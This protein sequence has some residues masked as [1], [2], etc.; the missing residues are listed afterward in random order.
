M[1]NER[2]NNKKG[3]TFYLHI[4]GFMGFLTLGSFVTMLEAVQST[5]P[6]DAIIPVLELGNAACI[7]AITP[8]IA[9]IIFGILY[10][11]SLND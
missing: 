8:A 4:C 2:N 9:A 7:G 1:K 3:N 6:E 10:V 5:Y 11:K